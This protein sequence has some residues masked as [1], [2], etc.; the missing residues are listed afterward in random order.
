MPVAEIAQEIGKTNRTAM[1]ATKKLVAHGLVTIQ[2]THGAA[3]GANRYYPTDVTMDVTMAPTDVTMGKSQSDTNQQNRRSSHSDNSY[4]ITTTLTDTTDKDTDTNIKNNSSSYTVGSVTLADFVPSAP[5]VGPWLNFSAAFREFL[6]FFESL[7]L[8]YAKRKATDKEREGW[9]K[10]AFNLVFERDF[11]ELCQVTRW[12][13]VDHKGY[14]PFTPKPV[15]LADG[16]E[17]PNTTKVTRP[18][19]IAENYDECVA[20]MKAERPVE[21]DQ[22]ADDLPTPE[23]TIPWQ[24]ILNESPNDRDKQV[25]ELVDHFAYFRYGENQPDHPDIEFKRNNWAKTFEIMLGHDGRRFEDIRLVV[26]H[27]RPYEREIDTS[28][29]PDAFRLRGDWS[30]LLPLVVDLVEHNVQPFHFARS[31]PPASGWLDNDDDDDQSM[32][33]WLFDVKAEEERRRRPRPAGKSM[34]ST[35]EERRARMDRMLAEHQITITK[36]N[37]PA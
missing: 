10:S 11:D 25:A 18:Y 4:G 32:P 21:S 13:F 5:K 2:T 36:E 17:K 34:S 30:W 15:R 6:V 14:F 12:L 23:D 9:R 29:Y 7:A 33:P 27:L 3:R 24:P 35:I 1:R 37:Q 31:A 8:P 26:T 16:R 20:H 28:R 19:Q 22:P